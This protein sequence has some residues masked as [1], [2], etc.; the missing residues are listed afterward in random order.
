MAT[1]ERAILIASVGLIASAGVVAFGIHHAS[2]RTEA[3][4]AASEERILAEI[5]AARAE[6]VVLSTQARRQFPHSENEVRELVERLAIGF[7]IEGGTIASIEVRLEAYKEEEDKYWM[8][9]NLI[10]QDASKVPFQVSLYGNGTRTYR[11]TL[12]AN[13]RELFDNLVIE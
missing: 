1:A 7:Q 6:G 8:H 5:R 3:A 10:L 2:H 12:R 13:N 9:G 11:G 4:I